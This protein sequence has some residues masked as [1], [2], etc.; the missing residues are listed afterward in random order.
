M[1][2]ESGETCVFRNFSFFLSFFCFSCIDSLKCGLIMLVTRQQD[3]VQ[4]HFAALFHHFDAAF[5]FH[6]SGHSDLENVI[7]EAQ[8]KRGGVGG[9]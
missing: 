5:S 9:T 8:K 7:Y 3:I 1:C 2:L 6:W 4:M